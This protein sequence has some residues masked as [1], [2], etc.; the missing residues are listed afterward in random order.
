MAVKVWLFPALSVTVSVTVLPASKFVEPLIDGVVS[1]PVPS[2]SSEMVGACV[3]MLPPF[4]VTVVVL[5]AS[6]VALASTVYSPSVSGVCTS[7]LKSPFSSTMASIV[8]VLPALSV[9]A[10]VTVE[11]GGKS[12]EPEIVGVVSLP[13]VC[14]SKES[15]GAV[16]SMLPLLSTTVVVLPAASVASTETS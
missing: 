7:T 3:S 5:P 15:A 16:V 8:C 13:S 9:T 10:M 12:V 6:S 11:P 4:S 1:F 14:G 2:G